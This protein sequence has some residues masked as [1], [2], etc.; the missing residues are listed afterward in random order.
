MSQSI[1][2]LSRSLARLSLK[3][4]SYTSVQCTRALNCSSLQHI[5]E[6]QGSE[7]ARSGKYPTRLT[8]DISQ[9]MI[10]APHGAGL[11]VQRSGLHTSGIALHDN[12]FKDG[13]T[14]F[15]DHPIY[16]KGV[17]TLKPIP[18]PK[19]GGRDPKTGRIAIHGIG[20]GH[21]RRYRMVDFKRIGPEKGPPKTEKV[22]SI[23]Y[24]PNRSA[25]LAILAGGT[26]KRYILATRNMQAGNLVRTY[27]EIPRMPVLAEE[28]DAHPVGALPTGTLVHNVELQPHLGGTLV[29]AAGTT[30]QVLRKAAGQ[31]IL[32]LPSKHQISIDERCMVTVGQVSNHEHNQRIIGKAG[33]NRWL[34]KRPSSGLWKRK[35]GWAGRKIRPLPPIKVYLASDKVEEKES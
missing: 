10:C 26:H 30:A 11:V 5:L 29:R 21:K 34:G 19:S 17:Y 7:R 13:F 8:V 3:G 32:Q 18:F 22:V 27:G 28:G 12:R 4:S 2:N 24:D 20:G 14:K 35:G 6:P 25:R 33:R 16:K 31:V 1:L 15:K 23:K 9:H